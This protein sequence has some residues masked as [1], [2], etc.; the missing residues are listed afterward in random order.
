M[1]NGDAVIDIPNNVSRARVRVR[2][3]ENYLSIRVRCGKDEF[4]LAPP[5][6]SETTFRRSWFS[7]EFNNSDR[8]YYNAAPCNFLTIEARDYISWSFEKVN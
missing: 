2:S 7:A 6:V 1:G 3:A 8:Y 5:L 4:G